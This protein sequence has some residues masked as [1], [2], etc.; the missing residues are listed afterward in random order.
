MIVL[1]LV[2]VNYMAKLGKEWSFVLLVTACAWID[3]LLRD[4]CVW[5]IINLVF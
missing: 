4:N 1:D 2:H 5:C 3:V